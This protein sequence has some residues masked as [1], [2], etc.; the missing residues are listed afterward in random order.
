MAQQHRLSAATE[1]WRRHR[2][3][4]LHQAA[5][6]GQAIATA[7]GVVPSAVSNWLRKARAGGVDAL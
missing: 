1:E 5:W 4:E 7:L 2:G 6:T 3:V